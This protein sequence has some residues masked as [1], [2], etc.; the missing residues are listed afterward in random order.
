[1]SDRRFAVV[2]ALVTLVLAGVVSQGASG[3]PDG[4]SYVAQLHDFADSETRSAVADGPLAGY[5][6]ARIKDDRLAGGL[7]GVLGCVACFAVVV[8]MLR[9]RGDG[10]IR[11]EA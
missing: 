7:A 6:V 11:G 8:T 3:L 5:S 9:R 4:L 2:A 10:R 1:M